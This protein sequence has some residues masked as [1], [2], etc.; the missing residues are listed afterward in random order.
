MQRFLLLIAV[1]HYAVPTLAAAGA[2][3]ILD[4]HWEIVHDLGQ[5]S[6]LGPE[7]HRF[8]THDHH[9]IAHGCHAPPQ[10][11]CMQSRSSQSHIAGWIDE[12]I[13]DEIGALQPSESDL[14]TKSS[15]SYTAVTLSVQYYANGHQK[16]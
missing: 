9:A 13:N 7:P 6:S 1:V 14:P 2:H 5:L 8:R 3:P 11:L 16:E 10:I 15:E 12:Y 4:S